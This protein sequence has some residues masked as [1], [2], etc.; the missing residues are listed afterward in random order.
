M[1]AVT[2][3]TGGRMTG[4]HAI[5]QARRNPPTPVREA[6]CGKAAEPGRRDF[7]GD[8]ALSG[9]GLDPG[10]PFDGARDRAPERDIRP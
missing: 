5:A 1:H 6:P 3:A 9:P 2:S 7:A 8:I 10:E 4:K